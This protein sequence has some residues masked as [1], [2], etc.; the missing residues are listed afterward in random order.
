MKIKPGVKLDELSPQMVLAAVIVDGVAQAFGVEAVITSGSDGVHKKT[1]LHYGGKAFDFRTRFLDPV[2]QRAFTT[3][4]KEALGVNY[5]VVL[6]S[7]H[8]H[9]E[10]DPK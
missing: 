8:L 4:C 2:Q 7:D 10:Y 1:S 9:V 6:E 3:G 5:D